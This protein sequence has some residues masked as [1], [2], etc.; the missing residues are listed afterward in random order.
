MSR[1]EY[2]RI[3]LELIPEEII[4]QC[5]LQKKAQNV[6]IYCEVQKVMY[7]LPQAGMIEN[8]LLQKRLKT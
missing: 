2:V 8:D 7:G 1:F 4:K 5:Y 6:F 3:K